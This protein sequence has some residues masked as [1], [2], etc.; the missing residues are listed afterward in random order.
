MP[1]G[2]LVVDKPAGF[3]SHDVVNIVRKTYQ[4][5]KVGH[6][7]TLDPDATGVLVVCLGEATKLV[8]YL[9]AD[10]KVYEATFAL[11]KRTTTLD[12]SGEEVESRNLVVEEDD[13]KAVL[14]DFT[15][16][17]SQIPPM[18]SAIKVDGKKLYEYARKGQTIER[19]PRDVEI[20]RLDL[21]SFSFPEGTLY[22]HCSSGTYIRSLI[23]D[24]GEQLGTLAYMKTL[25][26]TSV[27]LFNIDQAVSV[28]SLKEGKRAQL[29]PLREGVLQ[30]PLL[31][32]ERRDQEALLR[33]KK[34][35]YIEAEGD[36][37]RLEINGQL[38][39]IVERVEH[40][41][42]SYIKLKRGIQGHG[43]KSWK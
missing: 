1:D 22:V 7:G 8:P 42:T 39:G 2:I 20:F 16:K 13:V 15:G 28:A 43:E 32:L 17:I 34:L 36:L 3:T 9:T 29:L 24:I 4:M 21:T 18:Y 35:D 14:K 40:S 41:G 6:T 37:W 27:G 5:K 31:S 26:R 12:A 19:K 25:R 30:L 33:G 38:K 10:E 23:D 11:G